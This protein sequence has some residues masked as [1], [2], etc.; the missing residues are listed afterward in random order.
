VCHA[1]DFESAGRPRNSIAIERLFRDVDGKLGSIEQVA[2]ASRSHSPFNDY[3]TQLSPEQ[4]R[5]VEHGIGE[6]RT[7]MICILR[8]LGIVA[9]D[10]SINTSDSIQQM[11]KKAAML[12][13]DFEALSGFASA[14][15]HDN[16]I[17]RLF[18]QMRN[19]LAQMDRGLSAQSAAVDGKESKP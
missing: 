10:P 12:L 6:L 4:Q 13:A 18:A 5:I 17:S 1:A 15:K 8:R 7:A 9:N 14:I 16:E 2:S 19:V 11:V 3:L